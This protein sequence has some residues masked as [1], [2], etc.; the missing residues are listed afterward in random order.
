M[1][2]NV[3]VLQAQV[4]ALTD[5]NNETR[6]RLRELENRERGYL[7]RGLIALGVAVTVLGGLVGAVVTYFK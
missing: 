5:S 4:A 6:L 1:S 2:V 3:E 7:M